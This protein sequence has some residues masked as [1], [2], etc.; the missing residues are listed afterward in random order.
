MGR[1]EQY[2]GFAARCLEIARALDN[3]QAKAVMVQ[4]AQMWSRLADETRSSTADDAESE[5]G[6]GDGSD[7]S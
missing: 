4:M 5:D 3:P 7:R 6:P 1:S 2:R